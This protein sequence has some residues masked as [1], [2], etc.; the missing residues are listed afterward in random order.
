MP[1]KQTSIIA[2][3]VLHMFP[4]ERGKQSSP[5]P[6]AATNPWH[7]SWQ[8]HS[9]QPAESYDHIWKSRCWSLQLRALD[10]C[11]WRRRLTAWTCGCRRTAGTCGTASG[12][13]KTFRPKPGSHPSSS[14]PTTSLTPSSS[15][16]R[17][18]C[19]SRSRGSRWTTQRR[20]FGRRSARETR[21]H[22]NA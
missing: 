16:R 7:A 6:P 20:Q 3:C 22:R 19:C 12:F 1:L 2:V 10:Y 8:I 15:R 13:E 9:V 17:F 4:T 18:S 14:S 11:W 5:L 21:W